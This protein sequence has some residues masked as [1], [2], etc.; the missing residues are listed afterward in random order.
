M[1]NLFDQLECLL[2]FV[3]SFESN[4]LLDDFGKWCDDAT[5]VFH[6]PPIKTSES[7]K[8]TSMTYTRG[9][10]PVLNCMDLFFINLYSLCTHNKTKKHKP[11][12]AKSALLQV[13]K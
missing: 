6:E 10:R 1:I 8:P 3:S 13:S 7:M 9:T 4:I 2:L 5:K 11:I 12:D